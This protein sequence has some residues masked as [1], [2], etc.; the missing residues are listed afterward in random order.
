MSQNTFDPEQSESIG[1]L[2]EMVAHRPGGENRP[3]QEQAVL[4]IEKALSNKEHL[5]IQAGTGTGKSFATLIPALLSGERI[6]YSTA[7]K[8]LSEQLVNL[9]VPTLKR[10]TIRQGGRPVSVS[11]IKGR[12]NY[13]C[14]KKLNELTSD[15]DG[16]PQDDSEQEGL[17]DTDSIVD[18]PDGKVHF[19]DFGSSS[20]KRNRGKA[21]PEQMKQDYAQM[22]A[23]A[24]KTKTGDK[25]DAP[26]VSEEVWKGFSVTNNECVG[27]K[28]CPFGEECFSESVR[29][30]AKKSQLVVTNHAVTA[31]NLE[32]EENP[33]LG[34]RSVYVFDEVHELDNFISSAWGTVLSEKIVLDTLKSLKRFKPSAQ[35][36]ERWEKLMTD[37]GLVTSDIN[38]YMLKLDHGLLWPNP[39]PHGLEEQLI[40]LR[41][42][43]GA[44]LVLGTQGNVDEGQS[45]QI[46]RTI[47]SVT[48]SIDLFLDTDEENVRWCNNEANKKED[49]FTKNLRKNS[50]KKYEP[51][52]PSLHC[53]PMRIG[54]RLMK[55]LD[56]GKAT[57]IGTSAT[58]TV[59][60]KF[61]TPIHDFGLDEAEH[62]YDALDVG[63]PFDYSKQAMF[64]V[65]D[66]KT[67]PS[68]EY[69]TRQEHTEAVNEEIL[70][71]VGALG[72]RALVLLTTTR[73]I[74]EVGEYLEDN[75]KD[76]NINILQQG[77]M[78]APQL[79][80]EFTR[81][82]TSVLVATMGMWHG[83]NAEGP[84]CSLVVMDKIPFPTLDDPLSKARQDYSNKQGRNGF[85]EVYVASANVKFA[86]GFG[87]LIRTTLDRGVVACLDT[88]IKTKPYGRSMVKSLP[89]NVKMYSNK[90]IVLGSLNRL[91]EKQESLSKNS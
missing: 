60:G 26:A 54:P 72:G 64:Y 67:F 33:M 91:R 85:M 40:E 27:R 78:P 65:P 9:D 32:A 90:E 12:D 53:A 43:L 15:I 24:D 28:A 79:I 41:N 84:T 22:F 20:K 21:T 58:I 2:R 39:L 45:E 8:Q 42:N 5:L 73:R 14:L 86:Q 30:E 35:N 75:L 81:D 87:R 36:S 88:R 68:A 3:E 63:T 1:F 66:D 19:A 77:D 50:K 48:E 23:W 6:V 61:D 34:Q 55:A 89:E 37:T 10:E 44:I 18:E 4:A 13:L 52:P 71:M 83:L 7:T 70:D 46:K 49:N 74:S 47:N 57:M 17:F 59:G 51:A 69:K 25:S 76:K 62:E 82:E 31:L 29:A 16:K 11:L 56:S 80:E 38:K